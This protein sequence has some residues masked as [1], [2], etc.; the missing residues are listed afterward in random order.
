MDTVCLGECLAPVGGPR[1]VNV[2]AEVLVFESMLAPT[3]H[4]PEV[5]VC[6]V[7]YGNSRYAYSHSRR[8][9]RRRSINDASRGSA[10]KVRKKPSP[11]TNQREE[12]S[13][14]LPSSLTTVCSRHEV[15]KAAV[16][17]RGKPKC[18]EPGRL[19]PPRCANRLLNIFSSKDVGSWA[20]CFVVA[21]DHK[22]RVRR[23]SG[24]GL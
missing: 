22:I 16:K 10:C 6:S 15:N 23:L 7:R 11:A 19:A 2:L 8:R 3:T 17:G 4:K 1:P 13:G 9:T 14:A 20:R 12:R 5:M 24:Q 18:Q 21:T